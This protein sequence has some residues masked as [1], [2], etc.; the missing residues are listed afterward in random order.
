MSP[1]QLTSVRVQ[2]ESCKGAVA[3]DCEGLSGVASYETFQEFFCPRCR[4]VNRPRT[5]GHIV[6]VRAV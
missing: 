3:L 4:K 1:Q 5:P 6:A 2:C